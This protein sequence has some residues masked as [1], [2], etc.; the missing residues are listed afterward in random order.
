MKISAK[1]EKMFG[2]NIVIKSKKV[3]ELVEGNLVKY[4]EGEETQ[5]GLHFFQ[6]EK[7]YKVG[8]H[9]FPIVLKASQMKNGKWW[10]Q[11]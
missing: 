9:E 6:T 11:G 5:T 3:K 10:I 4:T 2:E 1:I 8:K 7:N